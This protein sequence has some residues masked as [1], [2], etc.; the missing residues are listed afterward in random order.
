M[1]DIT[2][3]AA[4]NTQVALCLALVATLVSPSVSRAERFFDLYGGAAFGQST[5]VD[6]QFFGDP[7]LFPRPA[8]IST[9]KD[10]G[11]SPAWTV[12]GRVGYWLEPWPW[13]GA[14][15]DISYFELKGSRAEIDLIPMSFL[16]MLR[17]PM[18]TSEAFPNGRLQPYLGIGPSV[19]YSHAS[20]NFDPPFQNANHGSLFGDVGLDM[21][22]GTLWQLSKMLGVFAEYR[23]THVSLDYKKTACVPRSF[24]EALSLVCVLPNDNPPEVTVS[25]TDT[26]INV[27]HIL[28]GV[29]F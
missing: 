23:F 26:T 16:V 25:T 3:R 13:L 8:P 2:C 18:M 1:L 19:Y 6:H 9:T 21:R 17:Y 29:R 11:F 4:R 28:M 5:Q 20:V 22:A 27:H 15:M 24:A 12:G 7:T 10:L 14:A